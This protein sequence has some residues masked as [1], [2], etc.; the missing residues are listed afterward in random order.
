MLLW[1]DEPWQR[2]RIS[3]APVRADAAWTPDGAL[4]LAE[5]LPERLEDLRAAIGTRF[6][7]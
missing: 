5:I 7:S 6:G 4:R 3:S 2:G 1:P